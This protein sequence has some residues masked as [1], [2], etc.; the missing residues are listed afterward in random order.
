MQRPEE[1]RSILLY[2]SLTC[3]L[4]THWVSLILEQGC[5]PARS[6]NSTDSIAHRAVFLFDF[7]CFD[8]VL[9]SKLR[10]S[11]LCSKRLPKELSLQHARALFLFS[12]VCTHVLTNANED[13][14]FT[15][16]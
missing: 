13:L 12:F 1:G 7:F 14:G 4:D 5:Q 15:M 8:L 6:G 3:S 2:H 16:S 11:C 10:P 9:R